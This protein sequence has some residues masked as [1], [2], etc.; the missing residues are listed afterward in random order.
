MIYSFCPMLTGLFLLEYDDKQFAFSLLPTKMQNNWAM[1]IV[2]TAVEFRFIQ[3][4]AAMAHF[5]VFH[6]ITFVRTMQTSLMHITKEL[7]Q[8]G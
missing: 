8:V 2:G 3:F 1:K 6:L 7:K 4:L 5:G